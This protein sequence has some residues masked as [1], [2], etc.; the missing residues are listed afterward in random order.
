MYV[1]EQLGATPDILAIGKGLGGGVMPLAAI[2]ANEKLDC[3]PEAALGHYT[4]EKSPVACAAALAT[5]E[6]L[7]NEEGLLERAR[8]L[9]SHRHGRGSNAQ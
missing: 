8:E 3:A 1:C 5:L 9:G 4:H 7:S 2:L 6:T